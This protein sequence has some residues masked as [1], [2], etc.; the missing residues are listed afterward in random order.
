MKIFSKVVLLLTVLSYIFVFNIYSQSHK[1]IT[2]S[3]EVGPVGKGKSK[4]KF[5]NTSFENASQLDWEVDSSG[6]VNISLIYDHERSSP[7]QANG[8]WHFQVEAEPGSDLTLTL[9]NF[10]NIW[11]GKKASPVTDK[12]NCLI[13]KDGIRWDIIP[14]KLISGNRLQFNI[15][16]DTDKL[17][18]A[19]VEP[20]RISDLEKLLA[21]IEPSSLVEISI[22]GKTVEGRPLEIIRVG[23]ADA[24]YRIFLRARAHAWEPAGNW[25]VQGLIRSLLHKDAAHYLKKYCVYIMPMA[26]KD[27]V[28]RGRTRFNS[29]GVDLN[30]Q[31]DLP[32]DPD[33]APEKYAFE[34]WLKGMIQ[35]GKKPHLAI[36]LHNDNYGNI[37]VNLPTPEN[38]RYTANM[39]RFVSLLYKNTWFT[40]GAGIVDNPGSLGEGLAARFNVDACIYEFNYEW[41]AGLNKTPMGQDW[42][43]LGKQLR[44]VFFEYFD[45]YK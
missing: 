4:L 7:N 31:W 8:H 11:N 37:H 22:V 10:D 17:F 29:L 43:L 2:S 40:E 18:I 14:T 33:L 25:V 41:I 1:L 39:K 9:Q 38:S 42:E 24:P 35:K 36:D 13:S 3:Q 27:A 28:A 6:V 21:E 12:T 5:I 45:E 16:L 15:H 20:Y 44:E 34:N 30:R 19:S 23:N 26:N 32:A